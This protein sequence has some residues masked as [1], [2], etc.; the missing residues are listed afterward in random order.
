MRSTV[1]NPLE[2]GKNS[3]NRSKKGEKNFQGGKVAKEEDI[4]RVSLPPEALA[5]PSF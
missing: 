1:E 3:M 2:E 4:F 5:G